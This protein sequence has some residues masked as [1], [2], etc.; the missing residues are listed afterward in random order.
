MAQGRR[1]GF[2]GATAM[3]PWKSSISVDMRRQRVASFNGAT[4]MKPWKTSTASRRSIDRVRD[5]SMG[6][7]R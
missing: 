7:R 6:P 1:V 5:A 4:A 3:K 2:N